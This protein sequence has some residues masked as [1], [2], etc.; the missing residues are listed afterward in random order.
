MSYIE[1]TFSLKKKISI[2][3]GSFRGNGKEIAL[4]LGKSGSE[5]ILVDQ[6]EKLANFNEKLISQGIKS[7]YYLCD[8]SNLDETKK[9][10]SQIIKKHRKIDILVNNAGITRSNNFENYSRDDWI[11]T[12][13]VN[14]FSI[15]F[16]N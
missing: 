13:N 1:Q 14:L 9:I 11:D 8:L 4:A 15:F 16:Q 6:N 3:T 10:F 5:L 2:V 7:T 12:F